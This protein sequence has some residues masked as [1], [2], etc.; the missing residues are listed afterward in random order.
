MK[1]LFDIFLIEDHLHCSALSD[2][3]QAER[4]SRF[5]KMIPGYSWLL[6]SASDDDVWR[7]LHD[8]SSVSGHITLPGCRFSADQHGRRA[9]HDDIWRPDANAHVADNCRREA[10]D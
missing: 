10:T 7:A 2:R 6:L 5:L 4:P 8:N 1:A 3:M 9:F